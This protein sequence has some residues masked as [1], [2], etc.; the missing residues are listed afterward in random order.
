MGK[1]RT[2][3]CKSCICGSDK[4]WYTPF[5]YDNY[6]KIECM[7]CGRIISG[8]NY[9]DVINNWNLQKKE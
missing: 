2:K 1:I 6:S 3:K 8:N 9:Y 7:E 4:K 5:D